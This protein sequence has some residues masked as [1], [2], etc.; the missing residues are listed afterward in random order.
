MTSEN[1]NHDDN[2]NIMPCLVQE[3]DMPELEDITP[4]RRDGVIA[5]PSFDDCVE[6]ITIL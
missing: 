3:D 2:Q 4:P 5:S 1:Q 6:T